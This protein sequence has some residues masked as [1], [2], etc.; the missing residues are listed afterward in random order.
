[1]SCPNR[2]GELAAYLLG[3]L[4]DSERVGLR[5]H[6]AGCADCRAEF[7]ELAPLPGLLSRISVDELT[8]DAVSPDPGFTDRTM[9]AA[10]ARQRQARRRLAGAAAAILVAAG[11]TAIG[12]TAA[13]RSPT[14][15]TIRA[16]NPVTGVHG[17]V[18]LL[19]RAV[20]TQ[21]DV[22]VTGLATH[23]W[24]VMVVVGRDGTRQTA[25][26]WQATYTGSASIQGTTAIPESQV[27][28]V[29]V[30]TPSGSPLLTFSA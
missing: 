9:A 5:D 8:R 13:T 10:A 29:V 21:L 12:V 17:E 14:M 4:D 19:P 23:Q 1:M 3:A 7:D 6:L 27:S 15:A 24:C 28:A 20:G 16:A 26:S 18:Q 2:R 22:T 25:A 11:A 30:E